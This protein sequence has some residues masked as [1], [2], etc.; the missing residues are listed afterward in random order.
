MKYFPHIFI[1]C[2]I[3]L[4]GLI[5]Y[6]NNKQCT[7]NQEYTLDVHIDTIYDY[8]IVT[9]VVNNGNNIGV[10]SIMVDDIYGFTKTKQN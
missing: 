9:T 2:L 4:I 1:T 5:I 8:V 10:N 3:I 7:P 6:K